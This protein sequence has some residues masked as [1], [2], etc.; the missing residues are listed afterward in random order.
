MVSDYDFHIHMTHTDI[1]F[2]GVAR[3]GSDDISVCSR[4]WRPATLA[5]IGRLIAHILYLGSHSCCWATAFYDRG[6]SER[7]CYPQPCMGRRHA[8]V[9]V[10][11]GAAT[12]V[13]ASID[14]RRYRRV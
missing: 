10:E 2:W 6:K 9:R 7:K 13:D 11:A 4:I 12:V 5:K 14:R 8:A 1:H 3:A